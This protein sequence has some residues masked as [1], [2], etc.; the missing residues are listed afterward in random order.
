MFMSLRSSGKWKELGW[1]MFVE[2]EEKVTE[3]GKVVL[4]EDGEKESSHVKEI[5]CFSS[6]NIGILVRWSWRM[7][8]G[9]GICYGN[10]YEDQERSKEED[11]GR[12]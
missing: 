9:M 11:M 3:E 7:L 2:R 10:K 6:L 5:M 8:L 4:T 12:T 1:R